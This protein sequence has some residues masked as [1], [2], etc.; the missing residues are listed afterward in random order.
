VHL[1]SAHTV[2]VAAIFTAYMG[3]MAGLLAYIA[4]TGRHEDREPRDVITGEQDPDGQEDGRA[5][6]RAAA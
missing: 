3:S 4:R 6:L 5:E 1:L 2:L